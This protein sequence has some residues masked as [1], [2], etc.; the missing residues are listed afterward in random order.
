MRKNLSKKIRIFREKTKTRKQ[1]IF[2][3]LSV[4]GVTENLYSKELI[5]WSI[6]LPQLM[7]SSR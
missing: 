7:L 1:I 4:N 3:I 6:A 2:A 5:S